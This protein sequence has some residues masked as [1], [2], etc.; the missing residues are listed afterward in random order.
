MFDEDIVIDFGVAGFLGVLE[1]VAGV[2]GVLAPPLLFRVGVEVPVDVPL[3]FAAALAANKRIRKYRMCQ[4]GCLPKCRSL[5]PIP[6][7]NLLSEKG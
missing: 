6:W 2:T 5:S 3:F 1:G 7:T 4:S